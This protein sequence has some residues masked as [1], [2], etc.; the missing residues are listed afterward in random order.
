MDGDAMSDV[1]V[2]RHCGQ[3]IDARRLWAHLL[4]TGDAAEL[5]EGAC[6]VLFERRPRHG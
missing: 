2:C 1:I 6:P 5:P 3:R 4:D